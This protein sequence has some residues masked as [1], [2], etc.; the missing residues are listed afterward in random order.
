MTDA[1]WEQK[2]EA[3]QGLGEASLKMRAPG[4][5]YVSQPGV[6]I[7]AVTRD[8]QPIERG[9]ALDGKTPEEAVT[10]R[11]TALTNAPVEHK[12]GRILRTVRWNGWFWADIHTEASDATESAAAT[13]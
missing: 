1:T 7:K 12:R 2:F 5:W 10:F 4:T 8:K 6:E 3:M 9:P 11:W 13:S